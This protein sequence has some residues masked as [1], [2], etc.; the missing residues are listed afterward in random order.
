M[1]REKMKVGV[2]VITYNNQEHVK[3]AIQSVVNQSYKDWVCVL[4]DNGSTDD[5]FSIMENH[6]QV[7]NRFVAFKK[8]NEGPAAGRNLGFSKLPEDIDYI[9]FLD[10]DDY[11]KVDYLSTMVDYLNKHPHVG[12]VACQFDNID[13][14]GNFNGRGHRSRY[15]PSAVLGFPCDLPLDVVKTPFVS[16]FSSTGV[17]PFGVYRKSIFEQTNGYELKSQ[18]DSDMFCKMSLLAEVHYLPQY[19]YV[20]RETGQNLAHQE[21]Y[22]ATHN[23]FREKWDFY[24]GKDRAENHIIEEA[25][26]YY[27]VKHVPLRDFKVASKAFKEFLD[28]F[29]FHRLAWSILCLRNGVKGMLIKGNY[30][31]IMK[32]RNA[33]P[34]AKLQI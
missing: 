33:I 14:D 17:G 19:L 3:D 26:Y 23:L 4:V 24:I 34:D 29:H 25:L 8:T 32:R 28:T 18:E 1:I 13:N 21:S 5:T 2:V 6:C 30:K 10:G 12:L 7:D 15:A 9:H 31:R 27:Y 20:K 16:F 22:R 11:L